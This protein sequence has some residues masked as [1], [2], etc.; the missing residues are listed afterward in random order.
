MDGKHQP[1]VSVFAARTARV[2]PIN[3]SAT[4]PSNQCKATTWGSLGNTSHYLLCAPGAPCCHI[5]LIFLCILE[6]IISCELVIIMALLPVTVLRWILWTSARENPRFKSIH[7]PKLNQ[8]LFECKFFTFCFIHLRNMPWMN[9]HEQ[10][11]LHQL[12]FYMASQPSGMFL[13]VGG[14]CKTQWIFESPSR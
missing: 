8:M 13:E 9:H 1:P 7:T 10:T 2:R 14:N 3:K 4:R 5:L 11:D 6:L 12:N